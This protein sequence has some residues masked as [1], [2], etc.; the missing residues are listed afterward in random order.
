VSPSRVFV[1]YPWAPYDRDEY[2]ARYRALENKHDVT[3]EFAEDRLTTE[4]L[5]VKIEVVMTGADFCVFDFTG[6]NPNVALEYGMARGLRLEAYVAFSSKEGERDVPSDVRGIDS[7]RYETLDQLQAQL[8]TFL[9]QALAPA[10][11]ERRS[12]TGT[13]APPDQERFDEE[14]AREPKTEL[15]TKIE[16]RG[17]WV[18]RVRPERYAP[19][20]VEYRSLPGIIGDAKV[21]GRNY[22]F[23]HTDTFNQFPQLGSDW[24]GREF[25]L[26]YFLEYWRLFESGQFIG[27]RALPEDWPEHMRNP[28]DFPSTGTIVGVA[29]AA[30]HIAEAFEFCGW[31]RS[32]PAGDRSDRRDPLGLSL[33]RSGTRRRDD[34]RGPFHRTPT[35]EPPH[36][37]ARVPFRAKAR[38]R[39]AQAR[40]RED[41]RPRGGAKGLATSRA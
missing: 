12:R 35:T 27:V 19:G 31:T 1:A 23:P 15:R 9:A 18:L 3:F 29:G 33:E 17:H 2:K 7:L 38:A 21:E 5:L 16:S 41:E 28:Q 11:R 24:Y 6:F 8:D 36:R 39:G 26:G 37:D 30:R 40:V 14:L 34:A 10:E 32:V 4:Q 22:N 13:A 20:R 25:D